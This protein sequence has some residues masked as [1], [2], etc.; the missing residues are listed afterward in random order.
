M[1]EYQEIII[2][3]S[4]K[5]PIDENVFEKETENVLYQIYGDHHIYGRDTLLY[6]GIS[7]NVR[8]RFKAHL[9][10]VFGYVHGLSISIGKTEFCDNSL[11][12]PES[13]L[14]ANHKPSH[15]KEFIHNLCS[16]AKKWKII[17]I[18]NGNSGLLKTCCTNFWWVDNK[19]K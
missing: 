4:E 16:E 7:S 3:W 14:I 17:V 19:L 18:N 1:T 8:N 10:G 9:K 11:E 6:I 2:H 13:I 12:I 5:K 15:N